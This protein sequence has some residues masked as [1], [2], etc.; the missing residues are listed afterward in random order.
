ML[1]V[2]LASGFLAFSAALA[3][4]AAGA[5]PSP[6]PLPLGIVLWHARHS[7]LCELSI[8]RKSELE[9]MFCTCGLWQLPHSTLPLIS[10]TTPVA[11]CVDGGL[12]LSEGQRSDEGCNGVIKLKGCV[13][14]RFVPRSAGVPASVPDI[15]S[16]P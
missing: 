8:T 14:C 4:V 6:M 2:Q 12:A 10:V 15:D 1:A 9:S 16:W 3:P 13:V 11:S 7:A 5:E